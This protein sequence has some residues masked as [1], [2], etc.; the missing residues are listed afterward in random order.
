MRE[1]RDILPDSEG[2]NGTPDNL[3]KSIFKRGDFGDAS[4]VKRQRQQ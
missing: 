4:F 2:I 1:S 3:C